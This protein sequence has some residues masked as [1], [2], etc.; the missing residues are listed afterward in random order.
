MNT[1]S[2]RHPATLL[3]TAAGALLLAACASGGSAGPPA[4]VPPGPV[5]AAPPGSTGTW[6]EPVSVHSVNGTLDVEMNVVM[7]TLNVPGDGVQQ[8]RAW[9]L[10]K[11]NGVSYADSA[12]AT[13]F[14]GPTFRVRPGDTVRILLNNQLPAGNSNDACAAYPAVASGVDNFQDCFHGYNWTNIHYHGFHVT[15]DSIGDDVLLMIA[16]DSSYQYDFVI[17]HNQSPGTHWYHP[18]KHGSV[19]VQVSNGMSGAFIVEGGP[20]DSLA[21]SLGMTENL[22]AIQKVDS[23]L[24]LVD[25]DGGSTL[26][27]G[28]DLPVLTMRPNEVQRWRIVNE[29]ITKT[30]N[31]QIGFINQS[32]TDE[33]TL[34]DVARDGVQYAPANYDTINSDTL[35]LMAPGNRLDVFVR[36]PS[37]PGL[38]RL[39]VRSVANTGVRAP[40]FQAERATAAPSDTLFYVNVVADGTPVNT[41]LPARLPAQ[42]SFLANLPG[43]MN[44]AAILADTASLPVV[45]FADSNFTYRQPRSVPPAFFL[46][47]NDNYRMQFNS[48]S[49]YTP[50]NASGR[51]LPMMLDSV[52]TWKV[53]NTS[54]ATN[55]P[56]HIHI[57]PFQVIDVFYPRG[58]ADPNAALY[59]QLDSAAQ[60][61]N[62]PV[63]LDVLAL[64][65]PLINILRT[66]TTVVGS[67][68]TVRV[69]LADTVAVGHVLIRQAYEPLLNADGT[70]CTECGPATGKFVMHCHILGH[71][72]RGMMQVIEIVPSMGSAGAAGSGGGAHAGHGSG[73][74]HG[75]GSGTGSGSGGG[76]GGG[77]HRH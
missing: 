56:F 14:P 20:L 18:H 73:H 60:Q 24:N 29:N 37:T 57:N 74:S 40:R 38:H 28:A 71:E 48:D 10:V 1:H 12:N 36:A 77:G 62:A 30:T 32:G 76:G 31:Y 33:P 45:V 35:L 23:A 66:D 15:P 43:T 65:Q 64:P 21:N 61:R 7:A 69:T 75:S 63:W 19:A 4:A 8:L 5:G 27:N 44:P 34:Y 42:P 22:I 41:T 6:P 11:A 47:T 72:E 46:G 17:P 58:S 50:E 9:Q 67:D 49:V 55:H 13:A 39:A 53:V 68:T 2:V 54:Q 3:F 51:R 70:V 59:A 26:V 16:P 52:Q 25:G